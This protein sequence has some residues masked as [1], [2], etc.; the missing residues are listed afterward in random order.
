[1]DVKYTTVEVHLMVVLHHVAIFS[2]NFSAWKS[3]KTHTFHVKYSCF[4]FLSVFFQECKSAVLVLWLVVIGA[5]GLWQTI[6]ATSSGMMGKLL[7]APPPT[8]ARCL[9]WFVL[10]RD[11]EGGEEE[12]GAEKRRGVR[13]SWESATQWQSYV[14]WKCEILFVSWVALLCP[15][16]N[17]PNRSLFGR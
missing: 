12:Q 17:P 14:K 1:M 9:F 16:F 4:P 3:L 5:C 8:A 7:G 15:S 11:W 10:R 6:T 2:I 13:D